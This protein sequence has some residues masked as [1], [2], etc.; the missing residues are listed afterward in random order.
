MMSKNVKSELDQ[1]DIRRR[2]LLREFFYKVAD[3]LP[4]LAMQLEFADLDNGAKVDR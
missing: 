1:L 3:A 2:S 4:H